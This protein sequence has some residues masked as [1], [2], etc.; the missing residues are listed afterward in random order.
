MPDETLS[1][2]I[3][4]AFRGQQFRATVILL[5]STPL[6]IAWKYF[7]ST[8]FFRGWSPRW[9]LIDADFTAAAYQFVSALVLLGLIPTLIVKFVF[10]QPLSDYGVRL[11]SVKKGAIAV[12]VLAPVFVLA[13][14]VGS[15]DPQVVAYYPINKSAAKAFGLHACL[16]LLF[17]L[18]W[19]FH[20]R[21]YLQYGLRDSMGRANA[22][23]VQVLASTLLHIG[24][25]ASETF[26]AILG[27]L[28]WGI[29]AFR[30]ESLLAGLLLH[31]V[32]GLAVD[33]FLMF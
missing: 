17:Y 2:R 23:L 4:G 25:P 9:E 33:C 12:A 22:V 10:R 16:F 21:G 30:T 26:M 3:A 5:T 6:M 11:G 14:Y 27:G 28:L 8:E 1:Q 13:A 32:L 7:G 19:E 31:F 29:L 18:G 15:H 24:T 20:F